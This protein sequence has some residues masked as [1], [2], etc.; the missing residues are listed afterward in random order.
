[1]KIQYASDLHLEFAENWRYL[2]EHPLEKAGDILVLAG[3]IGYFGDENY[4][5]HPFWNQVADQYEQVIVVPGNHEF[6]KYYDI[7]SLQEGE[8]LQIRSNV[9]VYYNGV[10]NFGDVD[11]ILSTLWA[12]IPLQDA[13]ATESGVTDFH[14]IMFEGETLTFEQFNKEHERCMDFLRRACKSS[15]ASK[16]VIV[17]HHV[18]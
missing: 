2:K 12:H 14:R 10:V 9:K 6:Y 5:L 16:R 8:L 13:F 15:S 1:M 4:S 3:D 18:P 17:T 11:M 7:A